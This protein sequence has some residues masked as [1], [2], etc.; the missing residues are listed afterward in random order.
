MA[1]RDT[2]PGRAVAS[3]RGWAGAER[4]VGPGLGRGRAWRR[5]GPG[6]GG[7]SGRGVAVAVVVACAVVGTCSRGAGVCCG[8]AGAEV[9]QGTVTGVPGSTMRVVTCGARRASASV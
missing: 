4:G 8:S 2:A 3:D 1:R 6:R 5:A 9:G 7:A